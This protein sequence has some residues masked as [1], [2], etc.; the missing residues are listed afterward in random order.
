MQM[1]YNFLHI[2]LKLGEPQLPE[3]PHEEL[4]TTHQVAAAP[5][6]KLAPVPCKPGSSQEARKRQGPQ[7]RE[8]S[9][10]FWII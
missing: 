2:Q 7:V 3:W 4:S 6:S 9:N 10:L 8:T 5:D 1:V